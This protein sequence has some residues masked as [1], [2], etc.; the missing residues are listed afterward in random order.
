M[1]L[2]GTILKRANELIPFTFCEVYNDFALKRINEEEM[3]KDKP[4]KVY[5]HEKFEKLM[6]LLASYIYFNDISTICEVYNFKCAFLLKHPEYIANKKNKILNC[7]EE[8]ISLM[9]RPEFKHFAG[10]PNCLFL[11]YCDFMQRLFAQCK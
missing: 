3:Q 7:I 6:L 5:S 11:P 1:E 8:M 10:N 4:N 9:K 2:Y